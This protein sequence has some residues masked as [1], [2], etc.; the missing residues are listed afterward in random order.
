LEGPVSFDAANVTFDNADFADAV[1]PH[2]WR[3]YR[4]LR[5]SLKTWLRILPHNASMYTT[6][7][8]N[9]LADSVVQLGVRVDH[10]VATQI[11]ARWSQSLKPAGDDNAA[12]RRRRVSID[13][14]RRSLAVRVLT[15][16]AMDDRVG[17]KVRAQLW[18]W[19]YDRRNPDLLITV[20][21]VCGTGF[22]VAYPRNA[23]TRLRHIAASQDPVVRDEVVRA[24]VKIADGVE[25]PTLH[26]YLNGWLNAERPGQ[27]FVLARAYASVL[28]ALDPGS[29]GRGLGK[30]PLLTSATTAL[31][32]KA[33]ET[34]PP[35]DVAVMVAAWMELAERARP[36]YGD[37]M[38]ALL[39]S[40]VGSSLRNI[41]VLSY[42][43]RPKLV[44]TE[45]TA[46]RIDQLRAQIY[47]QLEELESAV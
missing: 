1:L 19:V 45:E 21:Q 12:K 34:M 14:T 11:A 32:T 41:G 4:P 15:D 8:L 47:T 33:Y 35:T 9:R 23:L 28:E 27:M 44:I 30:V 13:R 3:G 43:L 22:G 7:D 36:E 18:S 25:L 40:A 6:K 26:R 46:P 31:W 16:C 42:A 5:E 20:A 2:V 17:A 10:K 37:A 38:A 24:I 29:L 39:P